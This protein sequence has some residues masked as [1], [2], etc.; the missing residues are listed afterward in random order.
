MFKRITNISGKIKPFPKGE[1]RKKACLNALA[2]IQ[3]ETVTYLPSNPEAVVLNIDYKSAT[4]MQRLLLCSIDE[5][6]EINEKVLTALETH[7]SA[8]KAPFLARFKVRRCGVQELERIGI[9]AHQHDRPPEADVRFLARSE[10]SRVCW[11]AAIF[12]VFSFFLSKI[13]AIALIFLV[14]SYMWYMWG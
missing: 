10:D 3:L 12:K 1:A 4:P 6:P 11:Q 9:A 2:E 13:F 5:I 7:F 14:G 8:A